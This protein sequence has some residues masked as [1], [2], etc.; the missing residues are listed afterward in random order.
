MRSEAQAQ[1]AAFAAE[2]TDRCCGGRGRPAA[3]AR[4]CANIMNIV[5]LSIYIWRRRRGLYRARLSPAGAA[6]HGRGPA[7]LNEAGRAGSRARRWQRQ[8]LPV[9][10]WVQVQTRRGER[11]VD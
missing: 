6:A 7:L 3:G 10:P 2:V 11:H 8:R 9:C 5:V 4:P 1:S